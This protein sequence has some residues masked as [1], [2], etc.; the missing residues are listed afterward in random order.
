MLITS[1]NSH[2][3]I[4]CAGEI[5]FPRSGSEHAI[6]KYA[7]ETTNRKIRHGIARGGLVREFL[8]NFYSHNEGQA[9]GF[10]Y[11]YSQ[12]RYIPWLYPSA[13]S[14]MRS[15]KLS[16]IHNTRNNYLRVII[17][18]MASESTGIYRSVKAL[19][20]QPVVV[21]VKSLQHKLAR[22]KNLD[23]IWAT[24]FENQPY[25]RVAYESLLEDPIREQKRV[26]DFID[27]KCNGELTSPFSKL[28]NKTIASLIS[29]YEEVERELRGSEFEYLLS[30]DDR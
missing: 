25:L 3:D 30:D 14:Y 10:K 1:L 27:V 22:L 7:S 13:L 2:S 21:P 24:K 29:N 17:S 11:M 6:R 4:L 8:D 26:L 5:F 16:I 18:R 23:A 19:D 9:I 28:T 20:R 12:A 15:H